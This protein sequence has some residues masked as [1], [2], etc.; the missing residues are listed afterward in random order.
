MYEL[1]LPLGNRGCQ[2]IIDSHRAKITA[3]RPRRTFPGIEVTTRQTLFHESWMYNCE[4]TFLNNV[5]MIPPLLHVKN[6]GR[7]LGR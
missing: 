3:A 1:W 5:W 4:G 6:F 2:C 7:P